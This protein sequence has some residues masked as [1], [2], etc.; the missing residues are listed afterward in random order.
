MNVHKKIIKRILTVLLSV[1]L[2]FSLVSVVFSV[3]FY[4][5]LFP[6]QDARAPFELSYDDIDGR[7]YP[8]EAITLYSGENRLAA[9]LYRKENPKA[10]IVVAGGM[11]A[12]CDSH[13]P[14]IRRFCDEGYEVLCYSCTGVKDSEGSGVIGL[15][16][17]ALDL[18][19]ALDYAE[20]L[21]LP[22]LVYGHSA[23]AHAAAIFSDERDVRGVICVAGFES[24]TQL[25]NL[26]AK[27][28]VGILADIEYPFMCLQHFFLFGKRGFDSASKSLSQT[29]TPAL[30]ITGDYDS[31]VPYA[32]SVTK[33]D[34]S[35]DDPETKTL[36]V[37]SFARGTHTSIWLSEESALYRQTASL[38]DP[39]DIE[40]ANTLDEGYITTV[41]GFFE[42]ALR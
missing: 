19:C 16:Q 30:L 39:I 24:A 35:L 9:Y 27:R 5:R 26:W 34:E 28:Y 1:I 3:I 40:K 36:S 4:A 2:I 7:A 22:I 32:C 8:R 42:E 41:L 17:P 14:E 33:Y 21:S 18:S 11:G 29:Q 23:G 13:L 20:G 38:D 31:V 10:L 25:M 15:S 12:N 6:R 37:S